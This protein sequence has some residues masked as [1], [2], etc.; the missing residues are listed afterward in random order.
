MTIRATSYRHM[1]GTCGIDYAHSDE[2]HAWIHRYIT[3]EEAGHPVDPILEGWAPKYLTCKTCGQAIID[4]G[5]AGELQ[6]ERSQDGARIM[7]PGHPKYGE[8]DSSD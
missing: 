6:V 1:D 2:D 7:E 3:D 4:R 5:L 8:L